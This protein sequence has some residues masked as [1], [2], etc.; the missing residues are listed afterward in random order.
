M[1][2]E[3]ESGLNIHPMDQFQVHPLFGDG[4]VGMFTITNVTLWLF[5]AVLCVLGLMVLGTRGR[6]MIP[7]R[8]QST[9]ELA[10]ALS[11]P[12]VRYGDLDGYIDLVGDPTVPGF[13]VQDGWLIATDVPGVGCTVEM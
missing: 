13:R 1:A 8:I 3:G 5:V 2:T 11:S 7:G 9:A 12:T 6:A 4:G 10:F